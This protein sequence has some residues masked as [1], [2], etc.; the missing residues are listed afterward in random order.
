[1]TA[2]EREKIWQ[3]DNRTRRK[4]FPKWQ[5]KFN[6]DIRSKYLAA[7]KAYPKKPKFPKTTIKLLES[8]YKEVGR[9]FT[10]IKKRT[11]S[12]D[13]TGREWDKSVNEWLKKEGFEK[14]TD[15]ELTT[16]EDIKRTIKR[17][18]A[19]GQDAGLGSPQ[20][21]RNIQ[22]ALKQQGMVIAAFRAERIARTEVIGAGNKASFDSAMSDNGAEDFDKIWIQGRTVRT[23]RRQRH[24]DEMRDSNNKPV[25]L[26]KPFRITGM[27]HPH[28][29]PA[30]EVVNCG[31]TQAYVEKNPPK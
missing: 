22:N 7:S 24:L 6:K 26:D 3:K 10:N 8:L 30:S 12:S 11:K 17:E 2:L 21:T 25:P 28:K 15:I 9:D 14:A 1:M 27:M 5:K 31:C 13:L 23:Q 16:N 29:G 19:A 20:I 4:H 18:L